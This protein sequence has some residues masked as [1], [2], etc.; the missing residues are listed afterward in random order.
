MNG[1]KVCFL[2]ICFQPQTSRELGRKFNGVRIMSYYNSKEI[3]ALQQENREL[4]QK[5]EDIR[6]TIGDILDKN[7]KNDKAH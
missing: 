7:T 4:K 6:T 3:N 1:R 5:I 2:L